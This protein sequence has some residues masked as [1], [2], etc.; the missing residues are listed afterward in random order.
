MAGLLGCY[1]TVEHKVYAMISPQVVELMVRALNDRF[2][3]I[4]IGC[5][6]SRDDYNGKHLVPALLVY[7]RAF[8]EDP[9]LGALV[10]ECLLDCVTTF[11]EVR[12][13]QDVHAA[14]MGEVATGV[15]SIV[16]RC[17]GTPFEPQL[18]QIM[19]DMSV[20]RAH[21]AVEFEKVADSLSWLEGAKSQLRMEDGTNLFMA[22]PVLRKEFNQARYAFV[23]EE[24]RLL[25]LRLAK[26]WKGAELVRAFGG[27]PEGQRDL[28]VTP[29]EWVTA[30]HVLKWLGLT[31]NDG[32][33]GEPID[34]FTSIVHHVGTFHDWA[35]HRLL[36]VQ[37]AEQVLLRFKG[38]VERFERADYVAHIRPEAGD[39]NPD[40][41]LFQRRMGCYLHDAGLEPFTEVET[42][43][44]RADGVALRGGRAVVVTYEVKVVRPYDSPSTIGR[45][46]VDGAF[47]ARRYAR[48]YDQ[49]V[50]Y[51]VVFWRHH[52]EPNLGEHI[53]LKEG[54]VTPIIVDLRDSPSTTEKDTF[55]LSREQVMAI[56]EG[57]AGEDDPPRMP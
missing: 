31:N 52:S 21:P 32:S 11:Y 2:R 5:D 1:R 51:L 36:S 8:H 10:A 24:D 55:S 28:R 3:R 19:E 44:S 16:T 4:E 13:A 34:S 6:P 41:K 35:V 40:E 29:N 9:F 7:S 57:Y 43:P 38:R 50:G 33:A 37:A 20:A 26:P 14:R 47:K 30:K 18:H 39:G 54:S 12:A 17:N 53:A 15:E 46:I 45:R 22:L 25:L 48:Y 42:G 27:C 56:A 23:R 49:P